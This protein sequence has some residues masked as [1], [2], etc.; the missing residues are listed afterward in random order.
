MEND[1]R[2]GIGYD[3]HRLVSGRKLRLAGIELTY[4]LGLLGD[5]DADVLVHAVIEAILGAACMGDIG[6]HFPP[7]DEKYKGANSIELL[8]MIAE[9]LASNGAEVLNI[10]SV[11]VLEEPRLFPFVDAM[12]A[13]IADAMHIPVARV[14]I[15]ASTNQ[16]IGAVGSKKA[17]AAFAVALVKVSK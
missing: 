2:V 11:V 10:D 17:I 15:K 16:G 14:N 8:V 3:I 6:H 9:K 7:G 4:H 13:S 12:R 5:S 1:T